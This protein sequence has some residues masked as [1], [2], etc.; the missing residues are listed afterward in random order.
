MT[1]QDVICSAVVGVFSQRSAWTV[2]ETV[3]G[4]RGR[5]SS[6]FKSLV[7]KRAI[8]FRRRETLLYT[9]LVV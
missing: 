3:T 5:C 9:K 4:L 6:R 8:G 7:Q 2:L 1:I